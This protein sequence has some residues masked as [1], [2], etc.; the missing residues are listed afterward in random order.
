MRAADANVDREGAAAERRRSAAAAEVMDG[1][2][3]ANMALR[4][5]E[6]DA[7]SRESD[8]EASTRTMAAIDGRRRS[9]RAQ[10]QV[11]HAAEEARRL[12]ERVEEEER[13]KEDARVVVARARRARER[14]RA[15]VPR[16]IHARDGI[17]HPV[18]DATQ[19]TRSRV[20]SLVV[21]YPLRFEARA[22]A[23]RI[24]RRVAS[25]NLAASAR[26]RATSAF[27]AASRGR[28]LRRLQLGAKLRARFPA[29]SAANHS[30]RR[31]S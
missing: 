11:K 7:E 16:R 2:R 25:R 3:E 12:R 8:L 18:N 21:G 31:A 6:A 27:V 19:T 9:S 4:A 15:S 20:A 28:R 29:G 10:A 5:L 17:C 23:S 24:P 26:T 30:S 22:S 14:N 13:A 1:F